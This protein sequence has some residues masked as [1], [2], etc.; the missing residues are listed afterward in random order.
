LAQSPNYHDDIYNDFHDN[1]DS[2]GGAIGFVVANNYH[3][4]HVP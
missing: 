4:W 3:G 2:G 1:L